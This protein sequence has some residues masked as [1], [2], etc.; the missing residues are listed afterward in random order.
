MQHPDTI[1]SHQQQSSQ[2]E[3]SCVQLVVQQLAP[4]HASRLPQLHAASSWRSL[5]TS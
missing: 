4:T 2:R 5:M 1:L 3:E